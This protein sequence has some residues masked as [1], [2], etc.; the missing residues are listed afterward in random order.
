[1]G[2]ED[3]W[4]AGAAG[5]AAG[6]VVISMPPLP[7]YMPFVI[8][9]AKRTGCVRMNSAPT[10]RQG[11]AD[12]WAALEEAR[13]AGKAKYIGV[14]NYPPALLVEMEGYAASCM[15]AVNQLELHPRSMPDPAL[16]D[17]RTL[18]QGSELRMHNLLWDFP[19][20]V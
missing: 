20:A 2:G 17:P 6:A 5:A 19:A 11:R 15:P 1:V 9:D 16:P 12:T 18:A 7:V 8:L 13:A 4:R 10:A 14:S 3:R